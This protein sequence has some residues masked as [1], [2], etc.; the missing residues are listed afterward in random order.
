M[1]ETYSANSSK[2]AFVRDPPMFVRTGEAQSV[3][4]VK[5]VIRG[6]DTAAVTTQADSELVPADETKVVA[7]GK[8]VELRLADHAAIEVVLVNQEL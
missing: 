3:P 8:E 4:A 1:W 2:T 5:D 7:V 6:V